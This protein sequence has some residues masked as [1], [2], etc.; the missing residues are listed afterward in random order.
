MYIYRYLVV[1][2]YRNYDVYT[3]RVEIRLFL[4]FNLPF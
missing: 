2:F 3:V 1:I 4:N